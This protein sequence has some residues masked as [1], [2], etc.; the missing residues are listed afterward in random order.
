M[1]NILFVTVSFFALKNAQ[2]IEKAYEIF[3]WLNNTTTHFLLGKI[4]KSRWNHCLAASEQQVEISELATLER[5]IGVRNEA[6]KH[7]KWRE[8]DEMELNVLANLLASEHDW[9]VD[10]VENYIYSV[11]D[12]G[13]AVNA[14]D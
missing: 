3:S 6:L 5:I 9:E 11:I 14:E 2:L 12:T 13:P 4:D 10:S 7:G 8:E 1:K